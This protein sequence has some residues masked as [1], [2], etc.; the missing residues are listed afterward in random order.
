MFDQGGRFQ[1]YRGVG[2]NISDRKAVEDEI[3]Y[4]AHHDS[5]TTLP[6]RHTLQLRLG[7]AL[8]FAARHQRRGALLLLDLDHF[9]EVND[10]HGHMTGDR[11]LRM[12]AARIQPAIREGETLA[13]FGGD[14]FA[15]VA[16]EVSGP[17]GAAELAQRLIKLLSEPFRMGDLEILIGASI[18]VALFPD[19]DSDSLELIKRAD[20][21]LYRAKH[22]SRGGS[23]STS[24]I[25][26]PRSNDASR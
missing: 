25:W 20:R 2:R 15:V 16:P 9:K 10:A 26:M 23:A 13:R 14:E 22:E 21:A 19:G 6:N 7:Q 5:L 8:A 12:L 3:A 4:L 18:G 11:L 1:G 17:E 24:P